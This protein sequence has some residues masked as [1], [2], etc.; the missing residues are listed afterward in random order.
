M[1]QHHTDQYGDL[2]HH[3]HGHELIT[4]EAN[5]VDLAHSA[6]QEFED[7]SELL[8]FPLSP[9][10]FNT[11]SQQQP[12]VVIP[13]VAGGGTSHHN[14]KQS[15]YQGTTFELNDTAEV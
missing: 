10:T 1:K 13:A 14:N 11:I 5:E 12:N 4:N 15:S 9:M 3:E 6:N 8:E 2:Y 7:V